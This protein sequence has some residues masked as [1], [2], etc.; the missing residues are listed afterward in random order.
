[1]LGQ[2]CDRVIDDLGSAAVGFT[3]IIVSADP[4]LSVH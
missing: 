3:A 4:N 1:M 2:S